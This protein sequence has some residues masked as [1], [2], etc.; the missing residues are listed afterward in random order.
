MDSTE[1]ITVL[2][3]SSDENISLLFE[4]GGRF[5]GI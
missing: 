4:A 5:S 2:S 3:C 1:L